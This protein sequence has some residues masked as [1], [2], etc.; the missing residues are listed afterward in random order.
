MFLAHLP[1][2][3]ISARLLWAR[4][5]ATG[6]RARDFSAA[7]MLGAIFPDVDY[8]WMA[9]SA[10]PLANHHLYWTHWPINWP[11]LIL[12]AL[13]LMRL[14]ARLGA[15]AF[16]FCLNGLGHIL[17][18]VVSGRVIY[19]LLPFDG[20]PYAWYTVPLINNSP[21]Q[22]FAMHW[23]G[24]LELALIILA[25]AMW[26]CSPIAADASPGNTARATGTSGS[27]RTP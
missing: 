23:S 27:C 18:D 6:T 15:L 16:I 1:A 7:G 24:M 22:S 13:G 20:T 11:L 26:R 14:H 4:F 8:A 9:F 21:L 5:A 19:W 25:C 12:A 17:L 10:H 2:G 3:Y